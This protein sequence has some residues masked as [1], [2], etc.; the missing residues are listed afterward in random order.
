MWLDWYMYNKTDLWNGLYVL[1]PHIWENMAS[2]FL[3]IPQQFTPGKIQ[4]LSLGD[5]QLIPGMADISQGVF[6]QS[7]G[8]EKNNNKEPVK[9]ASRPTINML[10]NQRNRSKDMNPQNFGH[11]FFHSSFFGLISHSK[12]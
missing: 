3:V 8:W 1:V 4:S 12:N 11:F 2:T 5:S 7:V 10:E 9:R 6:M